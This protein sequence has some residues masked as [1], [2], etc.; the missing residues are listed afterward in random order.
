MNSSTAVNDITVQSN[1]IVHS[2]DCNGNLVTITK[3]DS[4]WDERTYD[5][6][7][8]LLTHKDSTGYWVDRSYDEHGNLLNFKDSTGYYELTYNE[9][10]TD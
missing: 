10:V 6:H 3:C 1:T 9:R 4:Y 8:R 7:C 2:C 5:D